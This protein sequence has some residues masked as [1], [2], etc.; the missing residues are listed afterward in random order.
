[1]SW[2]AAHWRAGGIV[3]V[4]GMAVNE[5]D[6]IGPLQRAIDLF[7]GLLPAIAMLAITILQR[8]SS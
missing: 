3:Q 4:A 1:L 5:T 8:A 2:L 6:L 7:M